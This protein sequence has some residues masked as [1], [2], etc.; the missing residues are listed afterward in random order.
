MKL[1]ALDVGER[2][3][4][5]AVS[6]AMGLIATPLTVVRRGSKAQDFGRIAQLLLEQGAEALVVGHPVDEDGRAGPQAQRIERYAA[7]LQE[8]LAAEGLD[9]PLIL[10]DERMSTQ[11]AGQVMS[12]SGHKA[13]DR[14]EWIDAV[15]AAVILQ[16]YLDVQHP[17]TAAPV[18]PIES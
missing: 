15:A 11:Q 16:E 2:R 10:W 18:E 7:A 17:P 12:A 1:L 6:D 4:G 9:L 8:S 13:R 14:K 5:V 3:V